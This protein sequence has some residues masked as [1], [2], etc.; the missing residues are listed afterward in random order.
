MTAA[1][2]QGRD[3]DPDA[4]PQRPWSRRAGLWPVLLD[5]FVLLVVLPTLAWVTVAHW[6]QQAAE[7]QHLREVEEELRQHRAAEQQAREQALDAEMRARAAIEEAAK[8]RSS[9]TDGK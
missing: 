9:P 5:G 3:C 7:R 1:Q 2:R 4:R 8:G 6:Q